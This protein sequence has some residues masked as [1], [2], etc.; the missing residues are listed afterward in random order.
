MSPKYK[1]INFIKKIKN[2]KD[3]VNNPDSNYREESAFKEGIE[4]LNEFE[5]MTHMEFKT[6]KK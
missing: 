6:K 5:K 1:A 4:I 3:L 2:L